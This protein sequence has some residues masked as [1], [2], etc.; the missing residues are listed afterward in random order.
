MFSLHVH[1]SFFN[2]K[3]STDSEV[4]VVTFLRNELLL[5][6]FPRLV[7]LWFPG[8]ISLLLM[9]FV[10]YRFE[11]AE[12]SKGGNPRNPVHS[13]NVEVIKHLD[14]SLYGEAQIPHFDGS[15]R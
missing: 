15:K 2:K 12:L 10:A 9:N 5:T 4:K 8:Y 11:V 6:K 14:H 7:A 1:R 3:R 13:E